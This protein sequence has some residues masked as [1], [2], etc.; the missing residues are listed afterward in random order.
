MLLD[1][2]VLGVQTNPDIWQ[3]TCTW[4]CCKWAP[5]RAVSFTAECVA[6]DYHG[7]PC[8]NITGYGRITVKYFSTRKEGQLPVVRD[9]P[10]P[11]GKSPRSDLALS[12]GEDGDT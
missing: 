6:T 3:E 12:V 5:K 11:R 2:L 9:M 10:F 7:N 1:T 4:K 8:M